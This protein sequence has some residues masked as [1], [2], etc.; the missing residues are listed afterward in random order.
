MTIS[1]R[2][3]QLIVKHLN[4]GCRENAY[5][6]DFMKPLPSSHPYPLSLPWPPLWMVKCFFS[7]DS[8][9][10]AFSFNETLHSQWL[11]WIMASPSWDSVFS[12]REQVSSLQIAN[13]ANAFDDWWWGRWRRQQ[14]RRCHFLLF[15][16]FS[17]NESPVFEFWKNVDSWIRTIRWTSLMHTQLLEEQ[18]FW[19]P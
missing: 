1:L 9:P 15:P 16:S 12:S 14:R 13:H 10:T 17:E 6:L 7:N 5:V 8:T 19:L 4:S 3:L 18:V 11:Q 2:W